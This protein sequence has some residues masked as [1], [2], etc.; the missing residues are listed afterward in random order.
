MTPARARVLIL[1]DHA[2]LVHS[3][4][5]ALGARGLDVR[6]LPLTGRHEVF[7]AV[8]SAPQAVVLLDLQLGDPLGS[9][10]D[11]VGPLTDAGARVLVVSG[12]TDPAVVGAAV[13]AGAVGHVCKSE[14]FDALLVA[15]ERVARGENIMPPA[16]R[17]ELLAAARRRRLTASAEHELFARLSP[18]ERA[19]LRA[20]GDGE[21]VTRIAAQS[22]VS[23]ATVRTQVRAVLTKLDVGSQLEAVALAHRCGWFAGPEHPEHPRSA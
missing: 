18:R 6:A 16:R 19:V 13:E 5:A 20:L 2:L 4:C 12:V 22:H 10:V 7:A 3:L 15:V 17:T 1:D 14:P 9:G 11:L 21:A 8:R 23:V